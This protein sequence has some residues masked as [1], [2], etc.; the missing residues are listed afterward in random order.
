VGKLRFRL[1]IFGRLI[2]TASRRFATGEGVIKHGLGAGLRFDT[3]GS[4]AGYLLGT[5]EPEEQQLLAN[6]LRPGDTFYDIGANVG[7]YS[8]IAAQLVGPEGHVYAFEPFGPSAEIAEK[9]ARVNHFTNVTVIKVAVT[10]RE[11]T[12]TLYANPDELTTHYRVMQSFRAE[13]LFVPSTSIDVYAARHQLRAPNTILID[14]E[15][16]EID[17]LRGMLETLRSH[18]PV[19]MC[20]VHWTGDAFRHFVDENLKE[21]GYDVTTYAGDPLPTGP[22]RYHALLQHR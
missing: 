3:T 11:G 10:D 20:E 21:M 7:F 8:T 17:V 1:P 5:S 4:A 16:G 9:N 13:G 2:E 6:I 15:G 19:I 14:V 22:S 18:R 12:A